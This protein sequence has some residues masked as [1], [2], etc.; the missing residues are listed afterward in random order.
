MCSRSPDLVQ[1][2]GREMDPD[3]AQ[4]E[5][6]KS[7]TCTYHKP[8]QAKPP[9]W[10]HWDRIMVIWF[11]SN[12]TLRLPM[13]NWLASGHSLRRTWSSYYDHDNDTVYLKT[14]D[15]Y[16]KCS[17][18]NQH[19]VPIKVSDWQPTAAQ[20]YPIRIDIFDILSVSPSSPSISPSRM[21]CD[22]P[23]LIPSTV[24]FPL[25]LPHHDRFPLLLPLTN[26]SHPSTM[27]TNSVCFP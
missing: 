20:S 9:D 16:A 14:S 2:C 5:P 23:I 24:P 26:T 25:F 1:A 8:L 21:F 11:A 19:Y 12:N 17:V 22:A 6:S 18:Q 7:S 15:G 13:G 10:R 3:I 27:R 4:H